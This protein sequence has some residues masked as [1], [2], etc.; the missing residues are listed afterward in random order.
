MVGG[1]QVAYG[2][3]GHQNRGITRRKVV[4]SDPA[5]SPVAGRCTFGWLAKVTG[6]GS[7]GGPN[8]SASVRPEKRRWS[9]T[10]YCA[11]VRSPVV[12]REVRRYLAGQR[13]ISWRQCRICGI[14]GSGGDEKGSEQ[15]V[16]AT[17]QQC[18]DS[19]P[20][21]GRSRLPSMP[22]PAVTDRPRALRSMRSS[23][24]RSGRSAAGPI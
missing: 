7:T 15:R 6:W 12:G 23:R 3:C 8:V 2:G 5:D 17:E 13:G 14:G 18:H 19:F 11:H 20:N 21:C 4:T 10:S 1:A 9:S 24:S 22:S 16:R